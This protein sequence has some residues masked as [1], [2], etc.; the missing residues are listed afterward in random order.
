[1]NSSI[2]KIFQHQPWQWLSAIIL[3][4]AI[5]Y[6]IHVDNEFISGSL[7]GISTKLWLWIAVS[8]PIFHQLYVWFVWRIEL[9]Q[10]VFTN[11][12]GEQKAF[13]LYKVGFSI[14]FISRLI[15]ITIVAFSNQNSLQVNPLLIYLLVTIITPLVIYLFYSVKTYFTIDRAFGIDHFIKNY[16]EPYVKKGIFHFTDNG[17]YIFGL[18]ILYIPGLLLFSKAALLVAIFNHIYIW[19]HYYCTERPDMQKIYHA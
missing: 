2:R 9:Y 11:Y 16:D 5:Q 3:V 6:F 18:M 8:I 15:F 4:L 10:Q 14:L 13:K 19:P 17:M 7:W 1:M 12:I